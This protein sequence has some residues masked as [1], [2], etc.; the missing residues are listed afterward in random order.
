MVQGSIDKSPYEKGVYMVKGQQWVVG[1][2]YSLLKT[3]GEGSFSQVCLAMD[4]VD[5]EKVA[6]KRIADVLYSVDYAKRVLREICILRRIRHPNLIG[7]RDAFIRPAQTGRLKFQGGKLVPTSIDLYLALE[8]A[9][10][11]DLFHL[12]GQL[13][14]QEVKHMMWQLTNAMVF[15]HGL[16]VWHRDLKS[17]NILINIED[18]IRVLKIAD[19]GSAR[20]ATRSG[21]NVAEQKAPSEDKLC[22]GNRRSSRMVSFDSFGDV[23]PDTAMEITEKKSTTSTLNTYDMHTMLSSTRGSYVQGRIHELNR[24]LVFGMCVR[25]I[26][27]S[28]SEIGVGSNTATLDSPCVCDLRRTRNA[29]D[30]RQRRQVL[31][32][33]KLSYYEERI[34]GFILSDWYTV[35]GLYRYGV[36][37]ALE[38]LSASVA[39]TSAD[40]VEAFWQGRRSRGRFAIK[41][42]DF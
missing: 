13:T 27:T 38:A 2:R 7:L 40:V 33:T 14:E 4:N 32:R 34:R 21:Y 25:R 18:G 22:A 35:L 6:L 36:K 15:L 26:I 11:G 17:A 42:V 3:L 30:T 1:E 37:Y 12:K 20:S 39:G 31:G 28:G 29:Q 41:I 8:Y 10:G 16:H 19:L 5:G 9:N 24:Y 23:T